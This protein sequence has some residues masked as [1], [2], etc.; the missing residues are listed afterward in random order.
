MRMKALPPTA[1][2]LARCQEA[3][4]LE[5]EKQLAEA[6]LAQNRTAQAPITIYD[7]PITYGVCWPSRGSAGFSALPGR[8]ALK[9]AWRCG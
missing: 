5:F 7:N 4:R 8:L 2:E 3:A 1:E 9:S 6:Q